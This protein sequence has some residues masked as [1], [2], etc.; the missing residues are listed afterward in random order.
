MV[1]KDEF[2]KMLN[3]P[4]F[5]APNTYLHFYNGGKLRAEFVGEP[6]PKDDYRSEEWIFSTNRA[7][8]PARENPPDKG[9]SRI[10]LPNGQIVLLKELLET[11][12]NETMGEA[13][14]KKYGPNLGI[15]VKIFDVGDNAHIP[16]HW[17]PSPQFA[18]KHLNS[19]YGKNEAWI[20]VGTRPGAKA[21]I[22][23]KKDIKKEEFRKWMDAQDV[24][25]IRKNMHEVKPKVG[26]VIFLRDSFVH[27]LGAG[28]CILEPQEPTDWNILAEWADFPYG[29]DDGTLGLNWDT[30]LE[31]AD[32]H[33]MTMDYL[34]NYVRRT[35]EIARKENGNVE[36]KLLPDE[37]KPYFWL[38]RYKVETK[39]AVPGGQNFYCAVT[40]EGSGMVRG[41][42]GEIPIKRGKS[43]FVP[44]GL[45]G[46]ELVNTGSGKLEVVFNYPPKI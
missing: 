19:P 22:G 44:I 34:N 13:H 12:P 31:A 7:V 46:Y 38:S 25:T 5:L 28:L 18:T 26:D 32:F 4:I 3:G 17:H 41:K 21:W 16:I 8:T 24:E 14:Y 33:E 37:A 20:V 29:K 40:T 23:W 9:F 43:L 42:F 39:M 45:D 10:Q 15:L 6:D 36:E 30:A 2:K 1:I 35:P 11:F 27:S